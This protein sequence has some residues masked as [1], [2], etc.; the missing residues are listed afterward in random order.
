M[1]NVR[2]V[3]STYSADIF[4]INSA[5]YELGGLI[6]MHDASGCNS[7][8]NTHDEPRWY[9][10]PSMIFISGLTEKDVVLGNDDKLINDIISCV[11]E[12][13]E[14]KKPKF[15]AISSALIPFFIYTDMNGI[16]KKIEQALGIK[17]F[18]FNTNSMSSYIIGTNIAFKMIA[19]NFCTKEMGNNQTKIEKIKVNLIGVTPLDFSITGN[20]DSL[21][22]IFTDFGFTINS[23]MAIGDSLDKISK[24]GDADA[25]IVLSS[26]GIS[27]AI[28][29]NDKFGTSYV[30]G[31][32]TCK[33]NAKLL[34][35]MIL[36][37]AQDGLSRKLKS[38]EIEIIKK[39]ALKEKTSHANNLSSVGAYIIGE[40]VFASSARY[41]LKALGY[42][43]VHIICPTEYDC[44]LLEDGDLILTEEGDF[45]RIL[46]SAN[47][48]MADPI[49]RRV[50]SK[51]N[52]QKIRFVNLPH[53]AFSGRMYR[54][55]IPVFC[56]D[57]DSFTNWIKERIEKQEEIISND[58]MK[59]NEPFIK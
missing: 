13:S 14:E 39:E 37:S 7:T 52:L 57:D 55:L 22:K 12:L 41:N 40:P 31:L 27:A 29:L 16:A 58:I 11:N 5:L 26:A 3:L 36:R 56:V 51:E 9:D 1:K 43:E 28:A 6:V 18:A 24:A 50:L 17:T 8:Y 59:N 46:N 42:E 19:E 10:I 53:E 23:C 15:I 44:G 54:S 4:G 33:E 32:P 25:N 21:K 34:K 20:L 35:E 38:N 48:I 30:I 47:I 49:Y 2:R 45:E